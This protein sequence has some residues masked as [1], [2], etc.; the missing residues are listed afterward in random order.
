MSEETKPETLPELIIQV[1]LNQDGFAV[2][3]EVIKNEP[4]ALFML[5][6]AVD[7]VKAF[8]VKQNAPLIQKGGMMG[9]ARKVF[10]K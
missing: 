7:T 10:H 3:G 4:M 5:G 8:H 9:F 6:K 1:R 2:T